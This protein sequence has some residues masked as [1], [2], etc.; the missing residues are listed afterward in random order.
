VSISQAHRRSL[1]RVMF[2]SAVAFGGIV[3]AS[4]LTFVL[5]SNSIRKA[6]DRSTD[7]SIVEE[8]IA[9]G[10]VSSSYAQQL[11][12]YRYLETPAA[13]GLAEFRQR[14]EQVY[15]GIRQ[16]LFR[17]MPLSARLKVEA[18]KEAHQ[19]FEVAAQHAFDLLLSGDSSAARARVGALTTQ[20][21]TLE[22]TVRGFIAERERQ[23]SLL[24]I[25]QEA[26][27]HRLQVATGVIALALALA[28]IVLAQ[29][30][31]RRVMLPLYDL[32]TA[33]RELSG[34]AEHVRVAPQRY[35]EFQLL[36]DSFDGM[37]D[38]IR[39]SREEVQAR[40]R[41]LTQT[42]DDLRRAQQELVQ[43]EKLRAMGEMLAG[44][45]HEL[46]NP[47]A[48]ILGI[49]ECIKMELAD[50]DDPRFR[51]MRESL[52]D[53]LV[54]ESL[55]ARDLVRNLLHFARQSNEQLEH[56]Q[57]L[58][59]VEVAIG[60]RRHV[61]AQAEKTVEVNVAP[62]LYVV[63]Q[64]QKL[65]H[66]VINIANNALDALCDG[67]GTQ[68]RVDATRDGEWVSLAFEDE[69]TGFLHPDRAF[70]PFYTTKSVGTG[71]G[72][73]LALVH[74]FVQEFGGVVSADNS[75]GG[76]ARVTM[77]LRLAPS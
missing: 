57:L 5:L 71:T 77:R 26:V 65:Q 50:S 28:A 48:G 54:I 74:R 42:L 33:L 15:A 11:V 59:A 29:L 68:L 46:N 43:H 14:G 47:L 76:G 21:A 66:A 27:L 19:D 75:A 49:A 38:S 62:D 25:E 13:G 9:D 55:R 37:A 10:I 39:L 67:D 17:E 7:Q 34:G 18:I 70:D 63:A 73:G 41:E 22:Q 8:R 32:S 1:R 20:A 56:V 16:Y 64:A 12:A 58:S 35:Q 69:G 44:L 30:L 60:L 61:F 36:A 53:P 40:N 3:T 45:A 2:L 4:V 23:R 31:R 72:L 51:E 6:L 24:R 52:V